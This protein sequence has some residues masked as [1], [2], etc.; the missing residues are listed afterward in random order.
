MVTSRSRSCG[1][2]RV[3]GVEQHLPAALPVRHHR[4]ARD[5]AGH[6][7]LAVAVPVRLL[8]VGGQEV[9]EARAQVAGHVLDDHRQA[10]RLGVERHVQVVVRRLRQRRPRPAASS[11]RTAPAR[12]SSQSVSKSVAMV[13]AAL[14]APGSSSTLLR[15]EPVHPTAEA[16]SEHDPG[17][18]GPDRILLLTQS[19]APARPGT[20]QID[21]RELAALQQLTALAAAA[22]DLVLRRC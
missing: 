22:G 1:R 7:E 17:S 8:A 3:E 11:S 15:Q 5:R 18:P 4:L 2:Q 9:G 16:G 6:L 20:G 19:A 21:A 10:V 13:S 14:P 12:R